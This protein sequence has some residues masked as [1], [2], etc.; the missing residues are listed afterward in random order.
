ML[1]ILFAKRALL[2]PFIAALTLSACGGD[3]SR[4]ERLRAAGPN[5]S[6]DALMRVADAEIGAKK[7]N[8]CAACHRITK[9]AP[10]LGGPNLYGIFNRPAAQASP[11]FGYTAALRDASLRWNAATLDAWLKSPRTMVPA[12]NMQFSGIS[13]PLNRA[14]IIAYLRAQS[15]EAPPPATP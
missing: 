5:P 7:F 15:D 11:R 6:F 3:A 1:T 13:D 14:D 12:T 8:Q 10:D 4:D 9:G 2:A